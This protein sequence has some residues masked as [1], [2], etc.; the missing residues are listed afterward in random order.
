MSSPL[1]AFIDGPEGIVVVVVL[2]LVFGANRVPKLARQL[3]QAQRE[4]K[5]GIQEG[6]D[7]DKPA[8]DTTGSD[9]GRSDTTGSD[10]GR[11]DTTGAASTGSMPVGASTVIDA[12]VLP[13]VPV[14]SESGPATI[15]PGTA[16]PGRGMFQPPLPP[17]S[18]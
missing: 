14:E 1:L 16:D 9:A 2:L 13:T 11:S 17:P 6:F 15:D 10:A 18:A 7:G 5:K 12:T 8:S 4:L 3:G